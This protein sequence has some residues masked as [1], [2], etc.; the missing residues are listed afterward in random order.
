MSKPNKI[1]DI[2]KEESLHDF[3]LE[4]EKM[5][6]E[7]GFTINGNLTATYHERKDEIVYFILLEKEI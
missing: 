1:F 7:K 2:I 4:L 5:V 3:I 6:N